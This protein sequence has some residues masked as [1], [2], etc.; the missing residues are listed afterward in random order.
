MKRNPLIRP[1]ALLL[2]A[3]LL[4]MFALAE[5]DE[6]FAPPVNAAVGELDEFQLLPPEDGGPE[7]DLP[8]PKDGGAPAAKVDTGSETAVA[9]GESL[10][11]TTVEKDYIMYGDALHFSVRCR[12]DFDLLQ[13]DLWQ[14][15]GENLSSDGVPEGVYK[16][17][18]HELSRSADGNYEFVPEPGNYRYIGLTA[19]SNGAEVASGSLFGICVIRTR[20]DMQLLGC[21]DRL[22]T[23]QTFNP[24]VTGHWG[25]CADYDAHDGGGMM[26]YGD[27]SS[28]SLTGDDPV[29]P[30]SYGKPGQYVLFAMCHDHGEFYGTRPKTI[31]VTAPYGDLGTPSFTYVVPGSLRLGEDLVIVP[32]GLYADRWAFWIELTNEAKGHRYEHECKLEDGRLTVP[33]DL[34]RRLGDGSVT[35]GIQPV[36]GEG[37]TGRD[38]EMSKFNI[39]MLPE[40]TPTPTPTP[41]PTPT[42]TPEPT[43]TP[44]P[45]ATAAPPTASPRPTPTPS[46]K[47]SVIKVGAL[48]F[49]VSRGKAT[50]I[51]TTDRNIRTLIVPDA[52]SDFDDA[53]RSVD[54]VAIGANAFRGMKKLS[55]VTVGDRVT[56][57]GSGAFCGCKALKAVTLG[58]GL[59]RVGRQAFYKCKALKTIV[60]RSTKLTAKT[61]GARAFKAIYARPTFTCPKQKLKA[62]RK[63]LRK[64]GAPKRSTFKKP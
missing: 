57:I 64:R 36:P 8:A 59:K 7:G 14:Y 39:E 9:A 20:A 32:S 30:H 23:N 37:M 15:L 33:G 44:A 49:R 3:C 24:G 52:I 4:P 19:C 27:G 31:T 63:L 41:E 29:H 6:A 38:G 12:V 54:V 46:P 5:M 48:K 26:I 11:T 58:A 45:T 21:P 22:L 47:P 13:L 16:H 28:C 61:V 34:C 2:A 51:G 53:P 42:S 1:A 10:Y 43:P 40:P 25:S 18:T 56:A 60:I 55:R 17:V 50:L 62:Y 35:L